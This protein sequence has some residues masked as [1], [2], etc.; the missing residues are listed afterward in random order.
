MRPDT[1]IKTPVTVL[2]L[3][4]LLASAGLGCTKQG[5]PPSGSAEASRAQQAQTAASAAA[6]PAAAPAAAPASAP[7]PAAAAPAAQALAREVELTTSQGTITIELHG[8]KAPG[9]VANFSE[10]VR[11]GFY[12]GTIFHR[13]IDGFMI[14]GG[15][16]DTSFSEKPTRAPIQ[17]EATNGLR[18]ERG[19]LAMARTSDPHSAGAQFFI[20]VKDNAF[21]DHRDTTVRGWGYAVFGRVKKGLAVADAIAKLPTGPKGPFPQDVPQQDVVITRARVLR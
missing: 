12:D 20:N 17:N 14:Q 13:V 4:A 16:F 19:T 11:S 21:L 18:N 7:Q 15:G 6:G 9:T 5:Q 2:G 3:C 1:L 8:D 10:Y